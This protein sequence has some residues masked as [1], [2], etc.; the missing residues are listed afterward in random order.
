MSKVY[1]GLLNLNGNLMAAIDVETTGRLAGFH[2]IIQI[3]V[4]PLDAYLEPV[5]GLLPFYMNIQPEYV[6]RIDPD[7]MRVHKL[8]LEDLRQTGLNK[9][10]VA[11][12]FDEWFQHLDL[13]F[14][15]SLVPLAHNWAF[16]AGFLKHWLGLESFNQF[17]HPHPRDTMLLAIA[18]ND[19]A[20]FKGAPTPFG[21]LSLSS[22]CKHLGIPL[23]DNHNA[24]AD[25]IAGAKLYKTLM[26]LDI[27]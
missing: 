11:D 1:P 16:E 17:F 18:F 19:R 4:Q 23:L 27:P 14:R 26:Q 12:L 20:I 7:A 10:K 3:A 5:K 24:L 25:A 15:K 2:E 9:F 6:K 13:P 8:S 21:Y 22:L